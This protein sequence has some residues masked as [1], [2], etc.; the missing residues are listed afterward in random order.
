[1]AQSR[2]YGAKRDSPDGRDF[3][4][5]FS[6]VPTDSKVDLSKYVRSAYNQLHLKS[7]TANAVC[8][9]YCIDLKRQELPDF[10]PSR[11][12]LYYNTRKRENNVDENSGASLRDTVKAL[13]S[14][15]VCPEGSWPYDQVKF[16]TKPSRRSY[17]EAKGN[18][19]SKYERIAN[20]RDIN[21]LRACLKAGYPFVFGF[22]V[23][24][25]FNEC[26]HSAEWQLTSV[27][28]MPTK[29]ELQGDP[30]GGHAVVAVGYN[31]WKKTITVLNS[32]GPHW[33]V[34]GYFYMPYDCITNDTLCF[35]FWKIEFVQ[36]TLAATHCTHKS[37][38]CNL[39]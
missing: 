36:E 12:F 28:R 15:G 20:H 38:L 39:L 5:Q 17:Q 6:H 31:D 19:V 9:A 29:E 32:W 33:G 23:Y 10:N 14:E 18:I 8:A 30:E 34:N 26:A 24:K 13:K 1:M 16:R 35:D 21:Q 37:K 22:S 3:K 27:M 7:C 11:L 25:S 2:Y 4:V